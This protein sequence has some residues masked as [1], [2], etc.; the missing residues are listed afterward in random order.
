M[1]VIGFQGVKIED[2]DF[3]DAVVDEFSENEKYLNKQKDFNR[4]KQAIT[5]DK[6]ASKN[7]ELKEI[8]KIIKKEKKP[9]TI[10]LRVLILLIGNVNESIWI[11]F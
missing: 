9:M 11:S 5:S 2:L 6:E 7:K 10:I 4:L 3:F 1:E 8:K